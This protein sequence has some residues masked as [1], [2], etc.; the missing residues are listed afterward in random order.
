MIF[1]QINSISILDMLFW[2]YILKLCTINLKLFK[3]KANPKYKYSSPSH[4]LFNLKYQI[5]LKVMISN[6][7]I[8]VEK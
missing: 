3:K 8:G 5:Y 2:S 4:F 7:P 6:I 1:K